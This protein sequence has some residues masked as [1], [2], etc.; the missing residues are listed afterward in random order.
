MVGPMMIF[1]DG[2]IAEAG[3]GLFRGGVPFN[4]ARGYRPL[5][6]SLLHARIVDYVSAACILVR[7]QLFVDFNL[8]NPKYSPAYYEDT[9]AALV[10]AEHG[11]QTILQPFSVV[12]H[13]GK[14]FFRILSCCDA[15]HGNVI[16][17]PAESNFGIRNGY[18]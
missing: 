8:Y 6:Q 4:S 2:L 15:T 12:I 13:A 17:S 10:F 5:Q 9:D 14:K 16:L 3:G 18:P 7:R 1:E 11:W